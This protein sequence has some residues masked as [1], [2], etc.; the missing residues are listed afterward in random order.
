M[1]RDMLYNPET[2]TVW[3]RTPELAQRNDLKLIS[4]EEG[5]A[6]LEANRKRHGIEKQV[7]ELGAKEDSKVNPLDVMDEDSL[8]AEAA[9]LKIGLKQ[10]MTV[11]QMRRKIKKVV[12]EDAVATENASN[13]IYKNDTQVTA[14]VETVAPVEG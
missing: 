6:I 5:N 3:A 1:S 10:G 7:Q 9:K 11:E 14:A 8:R 4:E 13:T 2:G 12:A